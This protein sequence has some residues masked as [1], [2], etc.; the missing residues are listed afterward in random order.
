MDYKFLLELLRCGLIEEYYQNFESILI[1]FMDPKV[2]GRSILENSSFIVSSAH[3]DTN[4]HGQG[5]VA[6]LSGSTAEFLH[7][8]LYMNAGKKPFHLNSNG[9]LVLELKPALAGWLFTQK[10]TKADF[11]NIH[12]KWVQLTLPKNTYA[13]NFLGGVLVVYHNSKRRNTYG[14][15]AV[16][17]KEIYLTYAG[18]KI[19]KVVQS[20]VL[21]APYS[22]DVRDKKIERIDVYLN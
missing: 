2:Y 8:W 1:P 19:P 14:P 11:Y 18:Q 17:V 7:A 5:F 9:E 3:N 21:A 10:E 4:L 16:T 15:Q 12:Q 22:Q 20:P 13:F 6:R